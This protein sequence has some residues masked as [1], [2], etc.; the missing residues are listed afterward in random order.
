M[1]RLITKR[2]INCDGVDVEVHT[3]AESVEDLARIGTDLGP[4]VKPAQTEP[5]IIPIGPGVIPIGGIGAPPTAP[6]NQ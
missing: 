3:N 6:E 2:T 1:R 4:H 5:P